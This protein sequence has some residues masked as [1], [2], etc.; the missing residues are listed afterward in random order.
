MTDTATWADD[1]LPQLLA[2][3]Q[4]VASP[5]SSSRGVTASMQR[6]AADQ[7]E[8]LQRPIVSAAIVLLSEFAASYL[9]PE[10]LFAQGRNDDLPGCHAHLQ[11][12]RVLARINWLRAAIT[13]PS[14]HLPRTCA[15]GHTTT[16]VTFARA[17]LE[18]AEKHHGVWL[19]SALLLDALAGPDAAG[20]ARALLDDSDHQLL[21]FATRDD[22]LE[23]RDHPLWP[24]LGS[25]AAGMP[26]PFAV[27]FLDRHTTA[28][29]V[30]S[31]ATE[32]SFSVL[33]HL[34]AG[35]PR[36][37]KT[38]AEDAQL[39][40]ENS[41]VATGRTTRAGNHERVTN[42]PT[43]TSDALQEAHESV[44]KRKLP[45]AIDQEVYSVTVTSDDKG[46]KKKK[47]SHKNVVHIG[48]LPFAE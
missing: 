9:H 45:S 23:I 24:H 46:K 29:C 34:L 33:G 32:S 16:A 28:R 17:A 43:I 37:S 21:V 47:S 30:H 12:N 42:R 26:S 13:N 8:R 36:I 15:A 10:M 1:R 4:I 6:Y 20:L 38:R 39:H 41:G 14:Q 11:P 25:I 19:R 2:F 48:G 3:L 22:R 27:D 7:H 31:Q 40:L 35:R 5:A 18:S 44:R